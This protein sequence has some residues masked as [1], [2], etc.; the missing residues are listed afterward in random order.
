MTDIIGISKSEFARREGVDE[1]LVRKKIRSG[2]LKTLLTGKLDPALVGSPWRR[3]NEPDQSVARTTEGIP[4]RWESEAHRA[5]YEALLIKL[6]YER[7]VDQVVLVEDAATEISEQF[8][9][10]RR[11]MGLVT[12]KCAKRAAKANT[13]V[14]AKAAIEEEMHTLLNELSAEGYALAAEVA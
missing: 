4:A 14:E 5:H 9:R 8:G 3:G 10:V 13:A 2:H 12:A 11:R 6:K 7:A 1:S